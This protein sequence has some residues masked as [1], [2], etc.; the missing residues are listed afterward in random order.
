[1]TLKNKTLERLA[2]WQITLLTHRRH[3]HQQQLTLAT[4][5]TRVWAGMANENC[6]EFQRQGRQPWPFRYT[7]CWEECS[8]DTVCTFRPHNRTFQHGQ[9]ASTERR[10]LYLSG[11]GHLNGH[12]H[13]FG[14]QAAI[15][16]HHGGSGVVVGE[17][18][19]HLDPERERR[20]NTD[21]IPLEK[22]NMP[23]LKMH[24]NK[25]SDTLPLA[26][27][28]GKQIIHGPLCHHIRMQLSMLFTCY[29]PQRHVLL[30]RRNQYVH[31]TCLSLL[32][33]GSEVCP[34]AST[35]SSPQW[36]HAGHVLPKV[37]DSKQ[38]FSDPGLTSAPQALVFL[39]E[40]WEY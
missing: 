36:L 10:V 12:R 21:T 39:P 11:E 34:C 37:L 33:L 38:C 29:L 19:C 2:F 6:T 32:S 3:H 1:M 13:D 25:L 20:I 16:S 17:H 18:Q 4:E 15:E 5:L 30:H 24:F 40:K 35:W 7:C 14:Q 22:I 23:H 31:T 9:E 28:E 26:H 27:V 8:T